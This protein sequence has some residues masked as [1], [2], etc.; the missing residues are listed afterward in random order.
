MAKQ[1]DKRT[2]KEKMLAGDLYLAFGPELFAERTAARR[3]LRAFNDEHDEGVRLG[4]LRQLLGGFDQ[5]EP[6]FIEPPL[7]VDYGYN[8]KVGKKFY[9]NFNTVILDCAPVTIGDRVLF[10]PNVQVYAAS[11]PVE[12]WVR[13]GTAGPEWAKPITIGSDC[14]I[15]GGAII[16]PGVVIGEGCTVGAGSVVT[17]SVPPFSVVA[18]NPARVVRRLQRPD[19]GGGAGGGGGGGGGGAA[20]AGEDGDGGSQQHERHHHHE[21]HL[22]HHGSDKHVTG[23]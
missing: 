6:P 17:K 1:V 7:R 16:L 18:G 20:G 5:E 14:W 11:H 23:H 4:V 13:N 22:H 12:G 2:E 9:A 15:G 3:L 19:G 21:R 8:I 10:G